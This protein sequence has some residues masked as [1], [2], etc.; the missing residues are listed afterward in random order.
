APVGSFLIL[1]I[2]GATLGFVLPIINSLYQTFVQTNVPPDKLGRVSSIDST[3]SSAISPIG[4]L[5]A[6]PLALLLGIPT[7]FSY[8]ALIGILCT[9]GFWCFTGIRNVDLD[10]KSLV[11]EINSKIE[12][13]EI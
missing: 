5:V 12:E 6:G 9:I 8:C 7:L 4:S 1:G 11:D 10:S 3:I 13:I 2:G